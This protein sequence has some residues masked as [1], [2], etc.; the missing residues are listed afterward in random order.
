[1][2]AIADLSCEPA[3]SQRQGVKG[4]ALTEDA[5]AKALAELKRAVHA[6]LETYSNVHR[7]SGHNSQASTHLYEQARDIALDYLGLSRDSHEVVFCSPRRAEA[8]EARLKRGSYQG[9]SSL[10]IG[11]ALGVRALAVER[12]ALPRGVPQQTGGGTARLVS[13]GWV[14]WARAP[15]KFEAGTPAIVNVI[16]F[17]RALGLLQQ[18]GEDAFRNT[19]AEKRTAHQILYH[20]ALEPYTGREL[21]AELRRT[22]IGR[23]V[24]VPTAEGEKPY[25]NL[26]NAA[27]TRTFTPIWDAA[28]QTWR[29][30]KPI[31]KEIIHEVRSICGGIL[32]A[33]LTAYDVIFTSNT[34]E[35]INLVAESLAK[36]SERG[37][38]PVVLNTLLEHNSNELPW[39][40][41]PGL[42]L[43]RFPVD[44]EGFVDLDEL[45]TLLRAYN[46]EGRHGKKRIKLVTVSGAS[47]VLGVFNDLSAMSRIVHRYG[48]RLLV[49]AA[50]LVAHRHVDMEGWDIDY[51]AF[52][53]HK[54]YAPFGTGTLVARE[55]LLRFSSAELGLIRSS[56]EENAG[57]IAALGK[58]LVL[59]QRIGLDVI[60]AEEQALTARALRGLAQIPG[61]RIYGVKDPDSPR[62]AQ[63]GGVIVFGL[64]NIMP[65]R[66]AQE[67]AG[68]GGIGVRYGCHCAHL[69][70]K[71]LVNIHPPLELFQGVIVTL[72]PQVS[73]PGLTR[74]SLGIEN[75]AG[76]IDALVQV[77]DRIA[78]Q[79]RADTDRPFA[80]TPSDAQKQMEAFARAAAHKVFGL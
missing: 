16:A 50:Q 65:N 42:S 54:V 5:T 61:L 77:L 70:I 40:R 28:W 46:Q 32:G 49:D 51:L 33:P 1:M 25:V 37:V 23:G 44:A 63:K 26:D 31:Q 66:V 34:T 13:P 8:L 4:P 59:L 35:A 64:G 74:V 12:K 11:L 73:L 39:R 72:F 38:K 19:A 76:E 68:Q 71:R 48:A 2:T 60:Q 80:S 6:A 57:G 10:D 56:G 75:T 58:A 69:L 7:G 41:I 36:E 52:S 30:P 55:G 14:I 29:Q 53:A 3:A 47:N 79:P 78:R 22:L 15:E 18:F 45:E 62:F 27:S 43:I 17:A 21:L 20:D 9:L 24:R 67:L